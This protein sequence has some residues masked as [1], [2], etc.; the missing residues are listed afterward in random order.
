MEDK[1]P[2]MIF[3]P[4]DFTAVTGKSALSF[5]NTEDALKGAGFTEGQVKDILRFW[6][7]GFFIRIGFQKVKKQVVANAEI[8]KSITQLII[9]K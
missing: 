4:N 1:A 3:W 5:G 2:G 8:T 9:K 6:K 7:D